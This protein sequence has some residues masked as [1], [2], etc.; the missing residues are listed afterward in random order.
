MQKI[1]IFFRIIHINTILIKHGLDKIVLSIPVFKPIRFLMVLNPMMWFKQDTLSRGERIRLALEDLGPIFVKFGQ[2]ISTRRDLLPDD[3]IDE[4]SKLQDQVPP[5]SSDKAKEIVENELGDKVENLFA[6]FSIMPKAS[7]SIAQVHEVYLRESHQRAV[8]KIIRPTIEKRI[9]QDIE[10]L[11]TIAKIIDRYWPHLHAIEVVEGFDKVIHGELDLMR[12]AAN[13]SQLKRNF[14]HSDELYIPTIY[15]DYVT[16]KVMVMEYIEGIPILNIEALKKQNIDLKEL[17]E[18]GVNIFFTQVFR[19]GFFHADMH[20]GNIFVNPHTAQNPQYIAVDFG[21]MGTLNA[22]DQYYLAANMLAFFQRDYRKVAE[23]HVKSNWVASDT[24]IEDFE[25]AIRTVCEP[26]FEKPLH[27]IS[28]GKTLMHLFQTGRQFQMEVQPQLVLLQKTLLYVEGLGRQLY[29]ELDLWATAKPFL[30]RLIQNQ[31]GLKA[32]FNRVL[33]KK[34]EW[35]RQWPEIPE[36][37]YDIL[38]R[39]HTPQ[40]RILE[41]KSKLRLKWKYF[42]LGVVITTAVYT[43]LLI[44]FKK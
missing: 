22:D 25:C 36:M 10:L 23:L 40:K 1:K 29:P 13:A 32:F 6:E 39:M 3:V 30:E 5:F 35:G 27:E 31:M 11:Y 37:I 42:L 12:E 44:T 26:I 2:A 18:R 34:G 21:I 8:I 9:D 28:Y 24:R 43:L 14:T 15:W 19:D 4:L 16:K 20:P 33:D 38:K 17:A 7:A 41:V